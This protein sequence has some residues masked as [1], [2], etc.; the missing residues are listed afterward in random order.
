M[1]SA[2]QL[3]KVV[4]L[5]TGGGN[6]SILGVGAGI[7]RGTTPITPSGAMLLEGPRIV[8]DLLVLVREAGARGVVL[9]FNNLENIAEQAADHAADILRSL[10]DPVLLHDA[11]HILLVGTTAAVLAATST[12]AQVRSVFSTPLTL[13]PLPTADV[14][15]LLTARYRYLALDGHEPVPPSGALTGRAESYRSPSATVTSPCATR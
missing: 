6:L 7:T 1:L 3:V 2:Q 9:R 10:R 14:R 5:T 11:L 8:R 15:A 12:H 4:R 13:E